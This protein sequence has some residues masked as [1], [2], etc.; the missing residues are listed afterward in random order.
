M[1]SGEASSV[2]VAILEQGMKA[3]MTLAGSGTPHSV[4]VLRDALAAHNVCVGIKEEALVAILS[5]PEEEIVVAEGTPPI[6][7]KN[8]RIELVAETTRPEEANDKLQPRPFYSLR[9]VYVGDVVAKIVP[10]EPGHDGVSV[11]G[12]PVPAPKVSEAG[13]R[14][15]PGVIWSSTEQGVIVAARS[16]NAILRDD[17]FVEV[18]DVITIAH[19][20]DYVVGNIDFVGSVIVQG[21]VKSDIRIRVGL[22]LEVTGDVGDAVIEA[23]GDVVVKKGFLGRGNG[24]I[25][26]AGSVRV[27]HILNQ[28][29][30]AGVDIVIARESV[31]GD[32]VAGKRVVSPFAVILGGCVEAEELVEVQGLGRAEASTAKVRVGRR[33]KIYER[34]NAIEKELRQGDKNLVELKDAVYK[35]VRFKI[36]KGALPA[37]KEQIL[38]RL[39]K[40]LKQLPVAIDALKAE[41]ARLNEDLTHTVDAVLKVHETVHDN[42]YIEINGARKMTDSS[43]TGVTF[44]ERNGV[45]E[46]SGL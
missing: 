20:V 43:L 33:G 16:G 21:D 37:D 40:T 26:A 17:R 18:E 1:D 32:V 15:G 30:R 10:A 28:K 46:A 41:K 4:Q 13:P 24:I 38:V 31:N 5:A 42:V 39:Q 12:E 36:D 8:G 44:T 3:G 11:T 9:N 7:G 14:L 2:S 6:P 23:G 22:N 34:L 45:L 35:L 25:T 29:I 27:Q 19:D